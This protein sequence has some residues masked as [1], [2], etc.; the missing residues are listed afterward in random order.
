M[1][2]DLKQ[3]DFN[4]VSRGLL[5]YLLHSIW[6][7][8]LRILV[9][10]NEKIFFELILI[11]FIIVVDLLMGIYCSCIPIISIFKGLSPSHGICWG[12]YE[13]YKKLKAVPQRCSLKRCCGN[14]Q[15][16]Y[17]RALIWIKLLCKYIEIASAWVFFCKFKANFQNIFL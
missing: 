10:F 2:V 6:L 15:Q 17:R 3:V 7:K 16:I 8:G 9:S 1:F 14:M 12:K 4:Q 13:E 5:W 11:L